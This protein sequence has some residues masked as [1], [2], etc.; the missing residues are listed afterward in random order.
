MADLPAL[1]LPEQKQFLEKVKHDFSDLFGRVLGYPHDVSL[2]CKFSRR[3]HRFNVILGRGFSLCSF[4]ELQEVF[5][6][7]AG[8]FLS[9][10]EALYQARERSGRR[11]AALEIARGFFIPGRGLNICNPVQI[12]RS[13][14][15]TSRSSGNCKR[16]FIPGRG[17]SL[18]KTR[19]CT[20]FFYPRQGILKWKKPVMGCHI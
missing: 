7:P 11:A 1:P 13:A 17:F 10:S 2:D 20:H 12:S 6:Y 15:E 14:A 19:N 9:K 3:W 16:F 18:C 4:G 5:L 8:Y